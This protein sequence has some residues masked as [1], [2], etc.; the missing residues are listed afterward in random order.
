M[1]ACGACEITPDGILSEDVKTELTNNTLTGRIPSRG[2]IKV[3]LSSTSLAN[4]IHP[5]SGLRGWASHI[6]RATPTSGAYAT[7]EAAMSDANLSGVELG[8]LDTLCY[9][10]QLLGS[11]QGVITCTPEDKDF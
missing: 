8:T 7:T 11:G 9:Y 1:Q 10:A 4:A 5:V 2:V 6:E 3:V